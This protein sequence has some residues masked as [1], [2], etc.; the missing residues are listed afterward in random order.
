MNVE[1]RGK[2]DKVLEQFRDALVPYVKQHPAAS[3]VIY[4]RNSVSVRIRIVDPDFAG[5]SKAD[6]HELIWKQFSELDDEVLAEVS[7]LLLLTP[8]ETPKSFANLEFEDPVP[9]RI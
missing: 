1:I 2:V 5:I 9:S 6:R 4:R 3:I 7:I 8:E